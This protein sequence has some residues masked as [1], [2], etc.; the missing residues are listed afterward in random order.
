MAVVL[1]PGVTLESPEELLKNTN[2]RVL[3][4]NTYIRLLGM[5]GSWVSVSFPEESNG[6]G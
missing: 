4:Q 2:A 1:K 5:G 3:P 6:Q